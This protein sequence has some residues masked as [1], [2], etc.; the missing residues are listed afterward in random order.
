MIKNTGGTAAFKNMNILS[1][2]K[3]IHI[4]FVIINLTCINYF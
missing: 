3:Y 1:N 4:N 2:L